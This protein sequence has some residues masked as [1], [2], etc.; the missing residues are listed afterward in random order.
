MRVWFS[1]MRR[2]GCQ[3]GLLSSLFFLP[4]HSTLLRPWQ[5]YATVIPRE[6]HAATKLSF[7]RALA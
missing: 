7:F 5:G 1:N 2:W 4:A 3:T 6:I